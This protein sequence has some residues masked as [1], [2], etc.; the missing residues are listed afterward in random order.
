[1]RAQASRCLTTWC[2][3]SRIYIFPKSSLRERREDNST[4][5]LHHLYLSSV[6]SF[7]VSLCCA[8]S[9][10]GELCR[11]LSI[12]PRRVGIQR[13]QTGLVTWETQIYMSHIAKQFKKINIILSRNK[14]KDFYIYYIQLRYNYYLQ[15]VR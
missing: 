5:S 9:E 12:Q 8:N 10:T 2:V 4:P 11:V 15:I 1:M 13:R 3:C 6:N 14:E 7:F